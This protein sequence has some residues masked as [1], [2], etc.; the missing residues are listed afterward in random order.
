M[1]VARNDVHSIRAHVLVPCLNLPPLDSY[2]TPSSSWE[3]IY[4]V[5]LCGL[6][7]QG[8]RLALVIGLRVA[9]RSKG[10]EV[11]AGQGC[12]FGV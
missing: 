4:G 9:E 8:P 11:A 10:G 7:F 2:T 3:A 5:G 1:A 12:F 6:W